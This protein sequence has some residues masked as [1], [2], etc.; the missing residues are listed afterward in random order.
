MCKTALFHKYFD[1]VILDRSFGLSRRNLI[2]PHYSTPSTSFTPLLKYVSL[3]VG[4]LRLQPS[5][6]GTLDY[7]TVAANSAADADLRFVSETAPRKAGHI[8]IDLQIQISYAHKRGFA[9]VYNELPKACG[10]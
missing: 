1:A 9:N 4:N 5:V 3:K 8:Q 2:Y 10:Y 7:I 6:R